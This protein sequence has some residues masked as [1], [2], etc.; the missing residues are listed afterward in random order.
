MVGRRPAVFPAAIQGPRRAASALLAA[1]RALQEMIVQVNI[2]RENL[3]RLEDLNAV[4]KH[5]S[6]IERSPI[7][8]ACTL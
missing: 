4:L 1:Q 3:A 5:M 2:L 7:S 6:E 8:Q